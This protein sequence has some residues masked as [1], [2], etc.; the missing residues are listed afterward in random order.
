MNNF[1]LRFKAGQNGVNQGLSFGLK[2]LNRAIGG[3]QRARYYGVASAAKVGKSTF[4]NQSFVYEPWLEVLEKKL[5][6]HWLYYSFEMSRVYQ[7]FC[8]AVYFM[9]RDYGITHITLDPEVDG[10]VDGKAEIEFTIDYLMGQVVNDKDELILVK[11][12]VKDLLIKIYEERI[13]KLFGEYSEDGQ[14]LVRGYVTVIETATNPTGVFKDII[15]FAA[16]RG[17]VRRKTKSNKNDLIVVGYTPKD[18]S[19]QIIVITDH[20]RKLKSEQGKN[21]KQ[22]MD[23]WSNYCVVLRDTLSYTFVNIVHLNRTLSSIDRLKEFGDMLYPDS[24]MVKGSGNM[25]EDCDHLLTLFNPNDNRYN[26]DRHFGETIRAKDG[27]E[28]YPGMRTIHLVESRHVAF[29]QHFRTIM[30]GS[31]KR[32]YPF[33]KKPNT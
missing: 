20:I 26:L 21:E 23:L 15:K 28:L 30:M 29:P 19:E 7:E 24:D 2:V 6:V 32:F 8:A 27:D 1:I 11:E 33:V 9:H 16:S 10:T 25:A 4:I 22:T 12:K 3:V 14:L 13:I 5:N 18:P 31:V 17:V